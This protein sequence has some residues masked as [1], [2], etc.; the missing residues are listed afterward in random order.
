MAKY[1][2]KNFK[3]N[4]MHC[5]KIE[6]LINDDEEILWKGNPKKSAFIFSKIFNFLPFALLWAL[7]DGF[8]IYGMIA[9][10]TMDQLSTYL[11]VFFALFFL[12]H[13]APFWIWLSNVLTVFAQYKNIEYALTSKRIII[14]TGIIIDIKNIYYADIQSVNVKVGLV[15]RMFKVGDV[16]IT[17]KLEKAVLLDIEDPYRILNILQKIVNDIKTDIY[18]PNDLRPKENKGYKTKYIIE[19]KEKDKNQ[20]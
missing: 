18:Y 8:F 17:S 6:D 10:G 20:S 3:V 15:D 16:Y 7:F 13:L 19:L 12:I 9:T 11:I 5:N 1:N 4:E 14:R 2:E